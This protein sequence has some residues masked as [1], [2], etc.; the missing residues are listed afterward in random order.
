M[1]QASILYL[2][3]YTAFVLLA[4]L[5]VICTWFVLALNGREVNALAN[6]VLQ[7]WDVHGL[8]ALK[9]CVVAMVLMIC[10]FVGRK[11]PAAAVRLAFAAI[12]MNFFPVAVGAGQLIGFAAGVR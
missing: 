5:D 3:T 12:A 10:E 7:Q 11:R 1:L 2:K 6:M 4:A 8:L 9:F